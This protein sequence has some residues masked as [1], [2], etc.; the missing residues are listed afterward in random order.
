MFP[1]QMSLTSAQ[2]SVQ[3]TRSQVNNCHIVS[4]AG[5]FGKYSHPGKVAKCW[6]ITVLS[7]P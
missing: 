5:L 1:Q 4:T 7:F 3:H 6:L 2:V